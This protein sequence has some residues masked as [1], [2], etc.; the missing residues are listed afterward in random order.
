MFL[1]LFLK[2]CLFFVDLISQKHFCVII[3][4]SEANCLGLL[5]LEEFQF[6]SPPSLSEKRTCGNRR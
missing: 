3:E 4:L 1:S 6:N 5:I 2:I